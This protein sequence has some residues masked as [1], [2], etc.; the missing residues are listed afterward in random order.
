MTKESNSQKIGIIDFGG[1]YAHLIASR[2]RRIGVYTELLTNSESIEKY[3]EY[4]GLIFSGGPSSVYEENS[5]QIS[6]EVL[7]LGLPI[8]GICYGHQL[9][10]KLMGGIV[11]PSKTAEFG[12]AMIN[13]NYRS[14][15]TRNLEDFEKVWMSHGDEVEKLPEGF[16]KFAS[17]NDCKYAGVINNDKKIYG[18]QFHPEVSHTKNG[19]ILLSN[20]LEICNIQK[21][22]NMEHYLDQKIKELKEK[23]PENKKVFVLVS[24]GVDS[25]VAYSLLVKALGNNRVKGLLVDTGFM[26]KNEVIDISKKLAIAGIQID[27]EDAS[28]QYYKSLLGVTNP[29]IKR[30]I[31]GNLFLVIK[32]R[33]MSRII[34]DPENWILGQGT[35]YPDTIESGGTKLSQRIKTHHNRIDAIKEL[36]EAGGLIEPIS[37]LYKDEVRELGHLLGLDDSLINRHPFPGPG[38]AVRMLATD[39]DRT[40]GDK[41]LIQKSLKSI[42]N[43][44]FRILP[45][46]SVGVQGDS[47]TYKHC[48]VLNDFTGEWENYNKISS[49]ITNNIRDINRVIFEPFRSKKLNKLIFN[50]IKLDKKFSDLLREADAIVFSIL[51]KHNIQNEIWQMPVVLLPVGDSKKKYSIVLRPV[52]SKE[53][54]TANFYFMKRKILKEIVRNLLKLKKISNV[55]YDITNKPPGTIEWE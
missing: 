53:A 51:E 14:K 34:D 45:I 41:V 36:M 13:I 27:I 52:E 12:P 48:L 17:S 25:T 38:L 40:F 10:M 7:E 42:Q 49:I 44:S 11:S 1:Q 18:I 2:I 33:V 30:N 24:G 15:F 46:R 37:E 21:N 4:S 55:F 35:I 43:I 8:L 54:M 5:P 6:K 20:F 26:R 19:N 29:E 28:E 50:P 22:W 31:I 39:E 3:K 32:N 23:I 9:I 47:R 16:Q